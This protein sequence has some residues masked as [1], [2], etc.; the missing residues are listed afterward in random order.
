MCLHC[1]LRVSKNRALSVAAI[2]CSTERSFS[3]LKRVKSYLRF[4]IKEEKLNAL[5]ILNIEN[6]ITKTLIITISQ[7]NV[8]LKKTI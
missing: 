3:A 8:G 7:K 2:N 1:F 6:Y 4:N 5:E